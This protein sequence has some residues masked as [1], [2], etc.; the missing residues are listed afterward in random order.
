MFFDKS[1]RARGCADS[2]YPFLTSKERDTETGLDYFLARYYS[3]IQGRFTSPD[4]FSG[5]PDDLFDFTEDASENPTFYADLSNPQSLNKYSYT[6]NNPLA[7][8]DD[9]GHIPFLVVAVV[10]VTVAILS[11]PDTVNAPRR[12]DPTYPSGDGMMSLVGNAGLGPVRGAVARGGGAAVRGAARPLA[13]SLTQNVRPTPT[14]R[15]INAKPRG[16][17]NPQ[18]AEAAAK[19][20]EKHRQFKE[21]VNNKPG[22][23]SEPSLT[24]PNN[25]KTVKPDAVTPG[26]RPVELKPNTPTGRRKGRRQLPAQERATGKK[27]RVIYDDP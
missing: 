20:R 11:S 8:T 1:S 3:S 22:W 18:T 14:A 17:R 26:G 21:K 7:F 27:G 25:G 16:S 23:K 6:Y 9:D 12:N 19:G 2:R 15:N 13:R 4:E 10:V 5:G 24:D